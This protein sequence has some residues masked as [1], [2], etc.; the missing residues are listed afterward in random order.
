[1][2]TELLNRIA[3][4]I[5]QDIVACETLVQLLQHERKLLADRAYDT[6]DSIIQE[7][8]AWLIKL[9]Q[10]A[11]TR[12]SLLIDSGI[13]SADDPAAAF[14]AWLESSGQ[15]KLAGRWQLLKT[16][17]EECKNANEIN[18]KLIYRGQATHQKLIGILRG[19]DSQTMLYT[20]KGV[21]KNSGQPLPI[22]KA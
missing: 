2:Q 18:G 13:N 1:M 16:R 10:S 11:K 22:G 9:E 19:Q 7:K 14:M 20:D 21:K 3:D 8:S 5:E 15:Q 4:S 17:M 12:Q 6:L